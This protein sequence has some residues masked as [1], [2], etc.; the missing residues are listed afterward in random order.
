MQNYATV[1]GEGPSIASLL[2][3]AQ[4]RRAYHFIDE[5]QTDLDDELVRICEIPAPPFKE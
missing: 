1:T 4:I 5:L 3:S 2:K